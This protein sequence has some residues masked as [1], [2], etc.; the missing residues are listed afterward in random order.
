MAEV[1]GGTERE[2]VRGR[3]VAS[4]LI[5]AAAAIGCRVPGPAS[6]A[7]S[8]D[9]AL[10]PDARSEATSDAP[11]VSGEADARVPDGEAPGHAPFAPFEAPAAG[12]QAVPGG[13]L[14]L[15]ASGFSERFAVAW[16]RRPAAVL[17]RVTPDPGLPPGSCWQLDDVIGPGGERWVDDWS[18]SH[19]N[20]LVCGACEHRVHRGAGVGLYLLGARTVNALPEAAHL[21]ARVSLRDCQIGDPRAIPEPATTRAARVQ[22][23]LPGALPAAATGRLRVVVVADSA[24]RGDATWQGA[25]W[26]AAVGALFTI[27]DTA[28]IRVLLDPPVFAPLSQENA[29]L[30]GGPGQMEAIDAAY[31]RAHAA[32][33]RAYPG[34]PDVTTAA[35]VPVLIV[36]RL[37]Y[38]APPPGQ[39]TFPHG[40]T[41]RVP[42]GFGDGV[43]TDAVV[44]A[45]ESI[46][47]E[48]AA[49]GAALGV[50]M[51]HEIGHFLGLFHAD[52]AR[53]ENSELMAPQLLLGNPGLPRLNA[54]ER[55]IARIHP[56]VLEDRAP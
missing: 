5:A 37:R 28:G 1:Y 10:T 45:L 3:R 16:S 7:P 49:S 14:D 52:P 2:C 34:Q 9:A 18:A 4:A 55:D 40:Q 35:V 23:A 32:V 48:R 46:R 20:G 42:G 43:H 25:A 12:F 21:S 50:V 27:Y 51:A 54:R 47:D 33:A 8:G 36:P 41:F 31:R 11:I 29:A 13:P 24:L 17:V 19:D 6:E 38:L 44:I 15:A 39:A 22:S 53:G 26:S 56:Y 30:E